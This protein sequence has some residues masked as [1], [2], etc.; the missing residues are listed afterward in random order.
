MPA[1]AVPITIVPMRPTR[2]ASATAVVSS[3]GIILPSPPP[4]TRT[5]NTAATSASATAT[6]SGMKDADDG[7]RHELDDE[8]GHRERRQEDDQDDEDRHLAEVQPAERPALEP[9]GMI[10]SRRRRPNATGSRRPAAPPPRSRQRQASSRRPR[11]N[12]QSSGAKSRSQ[13]ATA[14]WIGRPSAQRG[15][16][17]SGA[18]G[19]CPAARAAWLRPH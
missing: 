5:P 3:R 13:R 14:G 15:A 18:C 8:A 19:P 12:G 16:R 6:G 2:L 10:D 1:R 4:R 17:R 7:S 9:V 11:A